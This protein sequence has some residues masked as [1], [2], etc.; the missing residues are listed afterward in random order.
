MASFGSIFVWWLASTLLGVLALPLTTQVFRFL[1]DKGL[2]FARIVGLLFT[3][4][5]AWLL[6]FAFN[7]P[8]TALLAWIAL[9]AIAVH[10]V[11][12]R[13]AELLAYVE[14]NSGLIFVY[15]MAFFALFFILCVVRMKHSAI[16]D[17]EKFMDF[18]FFNSIQRSPQMPPADPWLA[19]PHNYINYYYFGYF[20]LANFAR[21]LPVAPDYAYNLC[22]SLVFGVCGT[23]ILSLGFNLTRTLWAGAVGVLVFQVFGNLH[24]GLQ[25]LQ[26]TPFSWWE[27]TRLIKDVAKDGHYL[28]RWWWSAS[29]ASL[30][31][32]GLGPD[33]ARDGLISEF[34]AFSFLH[35]DLHPHFTALPL[36]FLVLA[37]GLNLV[38]NPDPQPLQLG[39]QRGRNGDFFALT[40]GLAALLMANTW[41]LPAY[42][43]AASLLL[44]CQQ[45]WLG[46]V[47]G[48]KW[49]KQWLLPSSLLLVGLGLLAAPFLV[50]FNAPAAQGF[51]LHGAKTGLHDT[52]LF[53]GLFLAVCFP[54]VWLRL[55]ALAE[56]LSPATQR[57][58]AEAKPVKAIVKAVAARACSSCGAK[59][60]PGKEVCGQCGTRNPEPVAVEALPAGSEL[61]SPAWVKA[62]LQLFT[63]PG[64]ALQHPLLRFGV[65]GLALLWLA[66]V[67]LWPTVSLFA[68]LALLSF[69]LVIARGDSAEGLF[70]AALIG[71]ASLLVLGCEFYYLK[72]GFAGNPNLTRMNTVFKFYFQAWVLLSV[73]LPFA[74]WWVLGRLQATAP[75]AGRVTYSTVM[76]ILALAALVYP[77]K[78][79]AFVWA[80]Y[81]AQGLQ[82]TLDG[83]VWFQREYPSDWAA[84]QQMRDRISGQPV[85][86]EAIGN[87]YTHFARVAA[88]TGFRSVQGWA[89][90]EGQWR[91]DWAWD[92][93][94][95][96]DK[97]YSTADVN[98]ARGILDRYQVDYVFVGQLEREKYGAGVDKFAQMFP[99]PFIQT[100]GTV[101]YK[102]R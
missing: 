70:T 21:V 90:H 87:A 37:L 57:S 23:A 12:Q 60:R 65:P 66:A 15:E 9:G 102:V 48:P 28:N 97:L 98:E 64:K 8:V 85:I 43:L 58:K 59:L 29:P 7:S 89:N 63:E 95:Q 55:R 72:D 94:D 39:K 19:G 44:F 74:L 50:F 80:D 67:A 34:P 68:L 2:G 78:A 17:Q 73:A 45:H 35:G 46:Q 91:K 83:S 42:G 41:D 40:L 30:T 13:R 5:V 62:C 11:R 24:G 18:A 3:G 36:A 81:D 27:P 47:Q 53:W 76:V 10:Q 56:G 75:F 86:A 84:V 71:L 82:P 6:G 1:P 69:G 31:A 26:G 25:V 20:L 14:A 51:G 93:G 61:G 52:L 92:T 38:K 101:V 100:G 22:V 96:V 88:Y 77:V 4:Y 99:Q 16:V 33:A 49:A 54:F 79:I 32:A